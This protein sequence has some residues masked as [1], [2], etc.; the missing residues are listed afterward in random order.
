MNTKTLNYQPWLQAII[1]VAQHYRMQPAEEQ[2][3]LQLDWNKYTNIDD[4]LSIIT[5]QVGLNVRKADFTTDVLNPWRLP[6]V[7]E[8]NNGQV[9]VIEKV[10]NEGNASLQLSGDQGL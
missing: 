9:A 3:R 8:F 2:I 5:R 10:D 1:T 7:V 4:M 6:V